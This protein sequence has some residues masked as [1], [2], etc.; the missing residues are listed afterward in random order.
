[1]SR[2][3]LN[4]GIQYTVSQEISLTSE[5]AEIFLLIPF[6]A[7]LL[8]CSASIFLSLY[9]TLNKGFETFLR[10]DTINC[11]LKQRL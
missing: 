7:L 11:D 10:M 6:D 4:A 9:L 2:E 1:L 5:I 8:D 3:E